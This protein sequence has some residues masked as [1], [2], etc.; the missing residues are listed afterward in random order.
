MVNLINKLL[1]KLLNARR[2]CLITV[3]G[4]TGTGKSIAGISIALNIDPTFTA[5]RVCFDQEHFF[6]LLNEKTKSGA[7]KLKKGMAIIY[8]EAGTSIDSRSWWLNK[9]FSHIMETFRNRQIIL[10]F[11]LPMIS[12]LDKNIRALT[13]L[14]V[15]TMKIYRDR[16][17]TRVI[18]KEILLNKNILSSSP[19]IARYIR[20]N[21][22]IIKYFM[23]H[24][25][26]KKLVK[27]YELIADKWKYD[28]A[29]QKEKNIREKKEVEK[30]KIRKIFNLKKCAKDVLKDIDAFIPTRV[31]NKMSTELSVDLIAVKLNIPRRKALA[32]KQEVDILRHPTT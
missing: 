30:N 4:S 2:N 22:N 31:R 5:D 18:V 12:M 16:K 7:F 10:I 19:Y 6:R 8:E 17:V 26:P 24:K 13:N 9:D 23:I 21:G 1:Q 27:E 14:S 20:K 15:H 32:V 29:L 25:P 11:T 3:T 28:L